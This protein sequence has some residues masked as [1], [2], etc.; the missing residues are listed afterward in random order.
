MKEL[1][2]MSIRIGISVTGKDV[3]AYS[4]LSVLPDEDP[5]ARCHSLTA[6]PVSLIDSPPK[7]GFS[8][9][10]PP[11]PLKLDWCLQR[12]PYLIG[13]SDPLL[14][15]IIPP[16]TP[17]A[18]RSPRSLAILKVVIFEFLRI[19]DS[20]GASLCCPG[21]RRNLSCRLRYDGSEEGVAICSKP[22]RKA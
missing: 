2:S 20:N 16:Q 7:L 17:Q 13:R 11:Y 12:S 14:A 21:A 10:V 19:I 22:R 6:K 18:G 4:C 9:P 3:C 15:R 5:L 8:H 1:I